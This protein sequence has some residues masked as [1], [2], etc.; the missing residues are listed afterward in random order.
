[1]AV[2]QA[3]FDDVRVR[4]A[5]RLIVDRE[6]MVAAGAVRPRPGRPTTCTA[7][8]T[9]ATPPTSRSASRTSSRPWRCSPRP[10]RRASTIDL[11]A[12]DDTAGL[13]ELIAVF[14]DQAKEAGRHRQ[15]QGPRRRHLLGR[16]VHQAHVRHQLLG[17]PPVP[18][19]GRRRQPADGDLPR[20]ALAAGGQRLR[21][22]ST[23]QALAETDDDARCEIIQR[24][25]AA[26]ST[27]RAGTSSRLQQPARR[28]RGRGAG[29]RRPAQRAQP[30][31]LRPRLQ[32]HLARDLSGAP[33]LEPAEAM[34]VGLLKFIA[35][36]ARSSA[37]SRCSSSRW[38]SSPLTQALPS[39]PARA[40]PRPRR[41]A[42]ASLRRQASGARP[43]P[44]GRSTQYSTGSAGCSPATRATSFTNGQP[45]MDFLGDRIW[46][47]LF[48]MARGGGGLDPAVDR[49]RR[50]RRAPPRQ[51]VRHA[52]VRR[53]RS[54]SPRCP[55]S[56]IGRAADRAVRHQRVARLPGHRADPA[57]RTRRGRTS[58]GSSCPC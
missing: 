9:P 24:D 47:S 52:D 45:I 29:L 53:P 15:R 37:S 43:R 20:D 54:S 7:C 21:G 17:H 19:P 41:D 5:M 30:R 26:R 35:P 22:S 32:E 38:S 56:S 16:R 8:S 25:A 4:Q 42:E 18:Q 58:K 2:D 36:A 12:P 48:L 31:P 28:P 10:A 13:P 40:H 44:A 6:E 57:R 11:F 33:T 1:M 34:H 27:T 39:D 3:P 55:S 23:T 51:G 49:H 46:N 50:L 14:A